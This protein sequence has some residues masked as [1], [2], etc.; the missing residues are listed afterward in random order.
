MAPAFFLPPDCTSGNGADFL[1]LNFEASDPSVLQ[2]SSLIL[3]FHQKQPT[4]RRRRSRF[5]LIPRLE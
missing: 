3:H 1:P 5:S 2:A 4:R